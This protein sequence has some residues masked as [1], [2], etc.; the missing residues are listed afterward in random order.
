M[1]AAHPRDKSARKLGPAVGRRGRVAWVVIDQGLSSVSNLALGVVVARE[2]GAHAYGA[3]S[4]AYS[5]YL[6]ALVLNRA[7]SSD[8]L[9]IRYS[10]GAVP[11]R[12]A[13]IR[14]SAGAA[15]ATGLAVGLLCALAGLAVGGDVGNSLL[16]LALFLP[17][18]LVQDAYRFAFF[19]LGTP[20]QAGANDAVWVL[21][22]AFAFA[23]VIVLGQSTAPV[24]LG[25]WGAAATLAALVAP[26]Q[27]GA[28]PS[29]R[30]ASEWIREH[31]DLVGRYVLDVISVAGSVQLTVLGLSLIAGL[32]AAGSLRAAWVL[33]GPLNALFLAA[34]SAAV[35]EGVR[36]GRGA[37]A[38]LKRMCLELAIV[39]A[40][41]AGVWVLVL[42]VMPDHLGRALLG[43][44]W[45]GAR[46]VLVPLGLSN[47]AVGVIVA[48]NS[49]LRV[50]AD[51][52]RALRARIQI[53][54]VTAV[55]GLGGAVLGGAWGAAVGLL[56]ASCIASVLWLV[57]FLQSAN[58][59]AVRADL[60]P[61][62][63]D[64]LA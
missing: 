37:V 33:L 54:P 1:T 20:A 2:V 5:I 51:A 44:S 49:G 46:E 17:G 47:I 63:G 30:Q 19:A 36:L 59:R 11:A 7:V 39:L 15:V 41:L 24:L 34:Q 53:L 13:A 4:I 18:L 21:L 45:H 12:R 56:V 6:L 55:G 28:A 16:A 31:G 42:A 29:P 62:L 10:D 25:A 3:F 40:A 22:Q 27:A 60:R 26:W 58:E 9:V 57:Q 14:R 64:G 50:L 48:A 32:Q 43:A 38:D 8:P 52:R 23:A 35:P 61:P